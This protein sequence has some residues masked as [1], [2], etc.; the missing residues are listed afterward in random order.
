VGPL[1]GFPRISVD[2]EINQMS[3]AEE[4]KVRNKEYWREK[5]AGAKMTKKKDYLA[6]FTLLI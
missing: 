3:C 4:T 1:F 6:E 2:Y 5:M